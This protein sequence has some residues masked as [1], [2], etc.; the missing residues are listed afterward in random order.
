MFKGLKGGAGNLGL[1][2]QFDLAVFRSGDLW[3]GRVTYDYSAVQKT[4]QPMIDWVE[5][6]NV[7]PFSSLIQFWGHNATINQTFTANA[8]QYTGNASEKPYYDASDPSTNPND[9]PAP[10]VTFTFDKIGTPPSGG[11][12]LRVDSQN[13]ITSALDTPDALRNIYA[14]LSFKATTPVLTQ[15][16][17]IIQSVYQTSYNKPP[18]DFLL[19][20]YQPIPYR[21]T[22]QSIRNGGKV[23]GLDKYENDNIIQVMLVALLTDATQDTAVR[24]LIDATMSNVIAYTQSAGAYRQWEYVNYAYESEDPIGNYGADNVQFLKNVSLKYDPGQTFQ[25]LVPGGW[26][27]GDARKRVKQSNINQF[28]KYR[29]SGTGA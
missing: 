22:V 7:D 5:Q 12:D 15:V 14:G 17:N 21:A 6:A 29:S 1:V 25:T 18:Y 9:F 23:F 20:E 24:E 26:K 13:N 4:F 28:G 8:Y 2:T 10:F 3:G 19:A 11:A 27:L 16:N